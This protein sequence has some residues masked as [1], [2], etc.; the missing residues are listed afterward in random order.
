MKITNFDKDFAILETNLIFSSTVTHVGKI[1][2]EIP[3]VRKAR[4]GVGEDVSAGDS[5]PKTIF[6]EFRAKK[7]FAFF[8][9]KS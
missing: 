5:E 3:G 4:E 9:R 1:V 8:L 2:R 6:F 7:I